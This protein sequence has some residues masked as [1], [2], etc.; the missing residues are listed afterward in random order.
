[1]AYET[2]RSIFTI[3]GI[4]AAGMAVIS[5]F[6]FFWLKIPAVIGDLTGKTARKGIEAIR[7]GNTRSGNKKYGSSEVNLRRG[8]LTAKMTPSGSLKEQNTEAG[9]G[10]KTQELHSGETTVLSGQ[11]LNETTVLSEPGLNETT[12]LSQTQLGE[13]NVLSCNLEIVFEIL[14]DITIIH[15]QEETKGGAL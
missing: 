15:T 2:Y 7:S 5:I 9:Y 3:A 4:A 13:N 11:G 14:Q 10:L 6:L 1:M 8:K 12:I